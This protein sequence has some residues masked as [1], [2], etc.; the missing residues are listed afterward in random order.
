MALRTLDI[1]IREPNKGTLSYA[2]FKTCKLAY[3]YYFL[4][5]SPVELPHAFDYPCYTCSILDV[6]MF[7]I[8][9]QLIQ[10][11]YLSIIRAEGHELS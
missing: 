1:H 6:F 8:T 2:M 4:L 3:D 5:I 11:A 9:C 10:N 7:H